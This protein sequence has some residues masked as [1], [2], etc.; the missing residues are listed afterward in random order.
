MT[1]CLWNTLKEKEFSLT[2]LPQKSKDRCAKIRKMLM[3]TW[4]FIILF[5]L[6]LCMCET[7]KS[8]VQAWV[9]AFRGS[10]SISW[11]LLVSLLALLCVSFSGIAKMASDSFELPFY[12]LGNPR[13]KRSLRVDTHCF[14]LAKGLQAWLWTNHSGRG[15]AVFLLA[16]SLW[17]TW[18]EKEPGWFPQRKTQRCWLRKGARTAGRH[19]YRRP[20]SLWRG[21][22]S[23]IR[24][25]LKH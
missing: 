22:R 7:E 19:S 4:W 3:G 10:V 25:T 9:C 21:G 5:S 12:P 11:L 23:R 14:W 17:P 16:L 1:W 15:I 24:V 8:G 13:G 6:L 2:L 18:T 20:P